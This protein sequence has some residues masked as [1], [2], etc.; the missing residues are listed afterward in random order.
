MKCKCKI[1]FDLHFFITI[2]FPSF[3]LH[4]NKVSY[5]M[6]NTLTNLNHNLFHSH[7]RPRLEGGNS[8]YFF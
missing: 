5:D 2:F 7:K 8:K 3:M 6:H 4:Q 1:F